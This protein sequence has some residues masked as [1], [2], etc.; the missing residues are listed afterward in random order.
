MY[1]VVGVET[2]AIQREADRLQR[3]P[4]ADDAAA[5]RCGRRARPRSARRSSA[6][7][8]TAGCAGPSR[9]ASSPAPSGRTARAGR[10]TPNI[11]KLIRSDATFASANVRLR[12]NRIGSIGCSARSSHAT[13]SAR[14]ERAPAT[15][16]PTISGEPQPDGVAAD[17]PPHDPEE[18]GAREHEA[19]AG[20]RCRTAPSSRAS[21]SSASGSS[22]RPTGTLSQKIQCHEMPL[23]T[24]PPT[25]GPNATA[26][27]LMPPHAPRNDAA[28]L[29]R[30]RRRRGS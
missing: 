16:A 17:E 28:P 26:R 25:S 10:S 23:T 4:G 20:R 2:A 1:G 30:A 3:E 14:H 15:S 29:R 7:P 27:P 19:R 11:P 24:A 13:N 8:S 18:A 9:A 5:P 6:S 21:R 22:T 12:K